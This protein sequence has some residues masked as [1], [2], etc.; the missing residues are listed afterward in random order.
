MMSDETSAIRSPLGVLIRSPLEPRSTLIELP[1]DAP[2]VT[3]PV[4]PSLPYSTPPGLGGIEPTVVRPMDKLA[5][6]QSRHRLAA[7]HAARLAQTSVS[8]NP[9]AAP[10]NYVPPMTVAA[11]DF[12][13]AVLDLTLEELLAILQRV[14]SGTAHLDAQIH[15]V[16]GR[17]FGYRDSLPAYTSDP[18]AASQVDPQGLTQEIQPGLVILR[19]RGTDPPAEFRGEHK[20]P[21]IARCI[22]GLKA[23]MNHQ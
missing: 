21:A 14:E 10:S 3:E 1:P 5:W 12:E 8:P 16:I 20:S 13:D 7:E 9:F 23:R 19:T 11:E 15:R 18:N 2:A 4:D 22:A 17:K 6:E